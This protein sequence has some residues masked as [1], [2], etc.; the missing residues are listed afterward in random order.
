MTRQFFVITSI[1]AIAIYGCNGGGE[2]GGGP[3]GSGEAPAVS[4]GYSPEGAVVPS[5]ETIES[6]EYTPLSRPLFLYV[7]KASLAKPQVAAFLRYYLGD[8][9][10][11][12]VS[13]VGYVKTSDAQLAEAKKTLEDAI[14]AAGGGEGEV[15]GAVDIDGSSTVY[16][17]SQAVA[18]EFAAGKGDLRVQVGVSGTGGGMKKFQ[19]G[20]IDICDAS[21]GIKDSEVEACKTNGVEFIELK[22]GVD[23]L[24]V[25]VNPENDW[26]SGLTVAELKKI[27]EPESSVK[28]WSDVNPDFPEEEI[29]LYGPD[30]DSG[31]FEYFTEEVCGEKGHIRS[32]YQQSVDDN[33]LVTGVSGDKYALGYFGY[34]YY[35]ENQDKLKALGVAP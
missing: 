14:K 11:E 2:N 19:A 34:A 16:P 23:G 20:E 10:R 6:G 21:R 7:N 18:E 5:P 27:W 17:I 28:K 33:F 22:V 9:G 35:V 4:S 25:V 13:E 24:T 3:S 12:L 15:T 8:E 30:T 26:C 1:A 32:D 29:V 31:T